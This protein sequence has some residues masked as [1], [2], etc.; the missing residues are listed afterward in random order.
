MLKKPWSTYCSL[1][2]VL[3]VSAPTIQIF[4]QTGNS[5]AAFSAANPFFAPSTLPFQ[6]PAF[7]KIKN[8]DFKLAMEEGIRQHLAEIQKIA[9]N[10][11]APTFENT[12]VA[13]EKSGRLLNR[14]DAVF[15]VLTGANTN[16]ELQKVEQEEAPKLSANNDATYLNTKLFKRVEAIYQKRNDLKLDAESKRLVEV[17]YEN[18]VLAGARLS[19]PD[20]EKLKKLNQEEASL[21]AKFSNQLLA[22]TKAG[23]LVIASKEELAGLS[24][25]AIAAAA[26]NAKAAGL[27]GKWLISL[28]NTTQQPELQS[29]T[30]RATRQKLFEASIN[31]TEKSDANDTRATIVSIAQIRAQKANLL[32]FPN[33]AAWKLQNQ[34]AKTP[35]V[36]EHFLSQVA[37]PT[38]AGAKKEAADIQALIDQQK[39]GFKLQPW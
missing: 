4:G 27:A 6:A 18:F 31:R 29:L 7:D 21:R 26:Q 10:P 17:E 36:V 25:G 34:M 13:M 16:P 3:T 30:N 2:L 8:S 33:Y 39:G 32:G 24:E 1:L 5:D 11:A 9:D 20:K 14:V 37:P 22:G 23:A 35:E 38:I 15:N 28:Q 12:L 19:E